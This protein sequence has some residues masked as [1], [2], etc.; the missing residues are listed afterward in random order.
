LPGHAAGG[1]SATV[2]AAA[3]HAPSPSGGC[4]DG[5]AGS[6]YRP[7]MTDPGIVEYLQQRRPVQWH[8]SV[9]RR[10]LTHLPQPVIDTGRVAATRLM[11][12][13]VR[14]RL[15]GGPVKL[16]LGCGF[17]PLSGWVNIDEAGS[18][19]DVIWDLRRGLPYPDGSVTAVFHE[20]MLE[21]MPY[22]AGL[23]LTRECLRVLVP[24]GVLRVVVPDAAQEI[25]WYLHEDPALTRM[26]PT[27]MMGLADRLTGNGHVAMYDAPTLV[28]LIAAAGFS[29]VVESS[30]G[31]SA[32]DPCPD[33]EGRR[34]A[35]L[36][37]EGVK[38]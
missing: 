28:A 5:C 25:S 9:V 13:V 2:T 18:R 26:A 21:H 35:S 36:Y 22:D 14:R 29:D 19:A 3:V 16:H 33:T 38:R 32:M 1:I 10:A 20:H 23:E 12:P 7:R 34:T 15:P 4:V 24:G 31:E 37:V 30:Y 11:A 6:G 27:A 8:P 17:E